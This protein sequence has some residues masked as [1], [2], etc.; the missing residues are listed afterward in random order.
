MM[1]SN[2]FSGEEVPMIKKLC[3]DS[4]VLHFSQSKPT[5]ATAKYGIGYLRQENKD[6]ERTGHCVVVEKGR[7][8]DYQSHGPGENVRNDVEGAKSDI[9]FYFWELAI[10]D[11]DMDMS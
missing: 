1:P 2:N 9:M 6:K 4:N 8:I 10:N 3:D 5:V 11:E 7:Y